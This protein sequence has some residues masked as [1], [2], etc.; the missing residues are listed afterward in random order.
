MLVRDLYSDTINEKE[1]SIKGCNPVASIPAWGSTNNELAITCH[2]NRILLLEKVETDPSIQ[3]TI[4][5]DNENNIKID[6]ITWSIN[7]RYIGFDQYK[8]FDARDSS[9]HGPFIIDL[10]DCSETPICKPI[11]RKFPIEGLSDWTQ[12]NKLA[13]VDSTKLDQTMIGFYDPDTG[14]LLSSNKLSDLK[15]QVDAISLSPIKN[16]IAYSAVIPNLLGSDGIFI[17]NMA[18]GNP[19]ILLDGEKGGEVLFWLNKQ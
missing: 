17:Q 16:W 3:K 2:D 12:D 10:H 19:P 11:P 18:D 4:I 13:I 14:D 6:K 15:V 8:L 1:I 5:I 9:S 7:G